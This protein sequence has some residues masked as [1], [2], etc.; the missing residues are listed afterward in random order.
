[1]IFISS[2]PANPENKEIV[3]RINFPLSKNTRG[4]LIGHFA[5]GSIQKGHLQNMLFFDTKPSLNC[6]YCRPENRDGRNVLKFPQLLSTK[7][8]SQQ[9]YTISNSHDF[10]STWIS[11][12]LRNLQGIISPD[13]VVEG[14]SYLPLSPNL[15]TKISFWFSVNWKTSLQVTWSHIIHKDQ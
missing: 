11:E 13:V 4:C 9:I 8:F 14:L 10:K 5:W 2:T 7:S 15:V 12:N 3:L 6:H 1:M